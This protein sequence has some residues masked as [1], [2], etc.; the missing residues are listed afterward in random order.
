MT[1]I[2]I[3]SLAIGAATSSRAVYV[4]PQGEGQALIYPYYTAQS[5]D[6]SA[7]NTYVSIVNELVSHKAVRVRVRE[8]RNGREVASFNLFLPW[9]DS[10]TAAI[11]PTADGARLVTRDRSCTDPPFTDVGD[12]SSFLDLTGRAFAGTAS[13]GLGTDAERLREGYIEAI[14]MAEVNLLEGQ[15]FTCADF[16]QYPGGAGDSGSDGLTGTLTLI[17]VASGLE[18]STNATALANLASGSM[19]RPA[20][21]P[22]PDFDSREVTKVAGFFDGR[23]FYR[24]TMAS[25]LA[26]VELALAK[27]TISN[28]IV[29]DKATR[30]ATD[31][32]FTFP[33]KRFHTTQASNDAFSTAFIPGTRDIEAFL[34]VHSREGVPYAQIFNDCSTCRA[35]YQ[36][37]SQDLRLPWSTSVWSYRT[38]TAQAGPAT[39]D[40][41]G[42]RNGRVVALPIVIEN[43]W[44]SL[45]FG[46]RG[47]RVP[48]TDFMGTITNLPD[49]S[50][51][52]GNIRSVGLPVVGFM[53]RTFRN[54]TLSCGSTTCMGNYGGLFEHKSQRVTSLMQ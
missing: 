13:D 40:V 6:G 1:R 24:A 39:S 12:G 42:S 37:F 21:D 51:T 4:N 28:E 31:W 45:V 43:G 14:N 29:L 32:V 26:A 27:Q 49:G 3:C 41:L 38:G 17:N 30:S 7:M 23:G 48:F 25:G 16:R 18:F 35:Q 10:F 22:Y 2:L 15:R 5:V 52:T 8:G 53:A 34:F 44:A 36:E 47:L 46:S 33:T 11:V 50:V 9:S 19:F 54:G 20:S